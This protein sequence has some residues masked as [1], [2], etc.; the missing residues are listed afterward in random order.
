M[1]GT[2]AGAAGGVVAGAFL[3]QGIQHLMHRNDPPAATPGGG[4]H[5]AQGLVSDSTG[6]D[7]IVPDDS[8]LY[9]AGGDD[10]DTV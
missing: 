3:Y 8:D 9:A 10:S 6:F 1:L 4:E 5:H 2:V 7:G